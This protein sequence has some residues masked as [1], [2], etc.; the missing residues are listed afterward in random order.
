MDVKLALIAYVLPGLAIVLGIP[1]ALGMVPPN[2]FYGY[3]TRKTLSSNDVWYR[4]NRI[5]GWS[6]VVAGI[7]AVG[8]NAF[9]QHHHADW[10]SA[11]K[12]F[13]MTLS[14]ALMLLLAVFLSAFYIRKL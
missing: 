13:F 8:H 10:P 14:T 12:Q 11:A 5:S 2:R 4:A 6:L 7:A 3:R 1:M 9:F